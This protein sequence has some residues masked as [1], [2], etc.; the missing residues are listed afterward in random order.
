M[1]KFIILLFS[2][3]LGHHSCHAIIFN[4]EDPVYY[5]TDHEEQIND[6]KEKL[7]VNKVVGVTGITGMGK[8]EL[9]RKYVQGNQDKYDIIAFFDA[10]VDLISQFTLL[11]KEINQQICLKEG[12]YIIENAQYVK[13]SLLEYLKQRE[14]WLLVFDNLHVNE[15]SKMKDIIDWHHN[16]HIVI[17]SQDEEL[18]LAKVPAPYFKEEHTKI[19]ISKIMKNPPQELIQELVNV[20]KGCPPYMIGH[21]ATFLQNNSH[22]TVQD[23]LKI[24]K[25]NNNKIKGHLGIIFNIVDVQ[26]KEFLFKISLLNNQKISRTLL[27]QLFE[28]NEKL[29]E[30]IQEIIRFGLME[31]ISDDRNNQVFRIHDAVKNELLEIAGDSLNKKNIDNILTKINSLIPKVVNNRIN[32]VQN[33]PS[34]ESNLEIILRNA[35]NYN[36][37]IH[38]VMQLRE[39]LFWYYWIGTRQLFNSKEMVEWFES[40]KKAIKFDAC[41][42]EEMASYISYLTY[43]GQYYYSANKYYDKGLRYLNMALNNLDKIQNNEELKSY[44]YATIAYIQTNLGEI[45]QA[46]K[47]LQKA[48]EIRPKYPCTFLG[49]G[50]V[51]GVKATLFLVK[52]KYQDAL[53]MVLL[54]I[55]KSH[56]HS[57]KQGKILFME[58]ITQASILNYMGRYREAYE[59][60]NEHVYKYLKNKKKEE[61]SY[62]FLVR[63]LTELSRSELGLNRI[64]EA[65]DHAEEAVNILAE[66][67]ARN[68]RDIDNS[69]D[70]Y[71]APALVARGD[72]L[73]SLGKIEESLNNYKLAKNIYWNIYGTKNIGKMDNVSYLFARGARAAS[74]L[75][76]KIDAQIECAYFYKLLIKFFGKNHPRTIEIKGVCNY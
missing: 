67:E 18:L 14:R 28:N 54:D 43:I 47:N 30:N 32:F 49:A 57:Q 58:Y 68:N 1:L 73:A 53:D 72:A 48:E 2:V 31:Q 10:N 39:K 9:V 52:G 13:K 44:V 17:C 75:P 37:N 15:N 45:L 34:L 71:V 27:E 70:V 51:E 25:K 11:A 21:S 64:I 76:N 26:V 46:E 56:E 7:L 12:C 66:E 62:I 50:L 19:I 22:I 60:I 42:N 65:F 38:K 36:A 74:K 55:N 24:M 59:I 35:S 20:L 23:Y 40:H 3:V 63:T 8:S 33:D 29:S 6:L 41:N 69:R 61:I 4:K 5:F 16:G